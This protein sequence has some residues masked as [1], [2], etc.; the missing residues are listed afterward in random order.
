MT[1]TA[2]NRDGILD[3][4]ERLKSARK[5]VALLEDYTEHMQGH[6]LSFVESVTEQIAEGRCTERQL[7]WLRD[8]V[9]KYAQ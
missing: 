9:G 2:F 6:E 5:C 8:L 7:A 4:N 3:D 1:K